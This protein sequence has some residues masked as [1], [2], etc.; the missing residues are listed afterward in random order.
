MTN[1]VWLAA[2]LL[3]SL[4]LPIMLSGQQPPT[5][6]GRIRCRRTVY[7]G[8]AMLTVAGLVVWLLSDLAPWATAVGAASVGIGA[9]VLHRQLRSMSSAEQAG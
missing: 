4:V 3:L 9:V 5:A 8:Q 7:L 1:S 6:A 2:L